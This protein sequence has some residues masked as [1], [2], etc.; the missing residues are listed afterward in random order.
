MNRSYNLPQV[1]GVLC[2]ELYHF[3]MNRLHDTGSMFLPKQTSKIVQFKI[4]KR[5]RSNNTIILLSLRKNFSCYRGRIFHVTE[6][7]SALRL[8]LLCTD[9]LFEDSKFSHPCN[10]VSRCTRF[11]TYLKLVMIIKL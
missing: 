5:K 2:D 8:E 10:R 3:F 1:L 9:N 4:L 6:D 7:G 11:S